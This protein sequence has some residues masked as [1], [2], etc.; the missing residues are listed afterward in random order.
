MDDSILNSI[1]NLLGIPEEDPSFDKDIMIHINS[2][3]STLYQIG[4][5]TKL[6]FRINDSA[7]KWSEVFQDYL[8]VVNMIIDYT[9][10]RVRLVFDPPTS[11]SVSESLQ[12]EIKELQWRI[13]YEI[14]DDKLSNSENQNGSSNEDY[15][16]KDVLEKTI[17]E[18]NIEIK[19]IKTKLDKLQTHAIVDPSYEKRG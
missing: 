12:R 8:N 6:S 18:Q 15:V 17:R 11:S 14:E 7:V 16:T 9:Y 13:Q 3:F 5:G 2:V 4:V 1:K 19:D 10:M